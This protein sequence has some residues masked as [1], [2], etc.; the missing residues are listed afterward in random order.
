MDIKRW[1]KHIWYEYE[2]L[3]L[4]VIGLV[5]MIILLI[6]GIKTQ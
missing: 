1:I 3:G 4:I 5:L 6:F 2:A